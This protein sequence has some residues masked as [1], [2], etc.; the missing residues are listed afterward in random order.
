MLSSGEPLNNP[1]CHRGC[2]EGLYPIGVITLVPEP[3]GFLLAAVASLG[4]ASLRRARRE[5]N[6]APRATRGRLCLTR[7]MEHET[8]FEPATS[9]LATSRSTN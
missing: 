1:F 9:T 6:K 5:R 4:L 8:G 7:S 3:D 2:F